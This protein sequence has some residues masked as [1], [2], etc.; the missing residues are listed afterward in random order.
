[1]S[2]SRSVWDVLSSLTVVVSGVG[3][4]V[5]TVLHRAAERFYGSLGIT[6]ETVGLNRTT[7]IVQTSLLIIT[8][9]VLGAIVASW[10][11][12]VPLAIFDGFREGRS[13]F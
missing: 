9:S 10:L 7:I 8:P 6:P 2:E 5:C 1:V 4:V 11:F 12:L 3:V 13:E